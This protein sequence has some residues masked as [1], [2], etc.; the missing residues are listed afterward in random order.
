MSVSGYCATA[1]LTDKDKVKVA[2]Y[3]ADIAIGEDY[4]KESD[5]YLKMINDISRRGEYR[6]KDSIKL[7]N[8]YMRTRLLAFEFLEGGYNGLY[9]TYSSAIKLTNE[10]AMSSKVGE[11]LTVAASSHSNGRK[12]FKKVPDEMDKSKAVKSMN[13]AIE[14]EKTSID[15]LLDAI[16]LLEGGV[17]RSEKIAAFA[18][19]VIAPVVLNTDSIIKKPALNQVVVPVAIIDSSALVSN[20]VKSY[21]DATTFIS[22]QINASKTRLAPAQLASYYSGKYTIVLMEADG[23]YRYSV[24]KFISVADAQTVID[25]EKIKGYIVGYL[26]NNRVSIA[27]VTKALTK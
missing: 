25:K 10:T 9:K 11:L 5:S 24:G 20:G 26:N 23:Y 16:N 27:E 4:L 8:K 17:G 13:M 19:P 15:R 3:E 7:T 2:Q 12:F 1:V 22:I 18:A 14:F 21:D 6:A